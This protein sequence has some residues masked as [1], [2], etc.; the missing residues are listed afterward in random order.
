MKMITPVLLKADQRG[1]FFQT[2][3][4]YHFS[5]M[6]QAGQG[7]RSNSSEITNLSAREVSIYINF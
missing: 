2:C 5:C 4:A 3:V 6:G 1:H 7:C